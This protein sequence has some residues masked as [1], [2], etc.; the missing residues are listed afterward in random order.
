MRIVFLFLFTVFLL[1]GTSSAEAQM[2]GSCDS[3]TYWKTMKNRAKLEGEREMAMAATIILKADSVLEYSC[4]SGE[5][6]REW[7]VGGPLFP[8]NTGA[9]IFMPPH[10]RAILEANPKTD[11]GWPMICFS[12]I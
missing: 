2:R 4:F 9:P 7:A 1:A 11:G 6:N 5:V 3:G 8:S 12:R 10:F